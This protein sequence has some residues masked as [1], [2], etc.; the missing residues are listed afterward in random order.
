MKRKTKTPRF[1]TD[2]DAADY[3]ATHDSTTYAKGLKEVAVNIAPA[4]RRRLATKKAVT[5]RLE[6][7]QIMGAKQLALRKSIPYQT[8]LRMWIAEGLAKEYAG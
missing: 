2:R 1:K 6:T 4:L 8:L 3:W 5:L 7:G